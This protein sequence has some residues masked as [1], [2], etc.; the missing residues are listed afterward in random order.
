MNSAPA[1]P[2]EPEG[3]ILRRC[4]DALEDAGRGLGSLST[5]RGLQRF[6]DQLPLAKNSGIRSGPN[7]VQ[8]TPPARQMN[9]PTN[10]DAY[11]C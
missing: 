8:T 2:E 4:L 6:T 7:M 5:G 9:H 10:L 11:G 3:D 1:D